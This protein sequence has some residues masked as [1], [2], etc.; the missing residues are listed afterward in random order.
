MQDRIYQ[1]SDHYKVD[2]TLV[3][4]IISCEST[5]SSTRVGVNIDKKTGK[6]WSYDIGFWQINNYF[7]EK[8]AK[9]A[10]FDIY[11][12]QQNLEYG[13]I[14]LK[15]DGAKRHWSASSSCWSA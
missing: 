5:A 15:K 6:A 4:R 8:E 11:D 3:E 10:G 13:F 9:D 1:L 2:P 12:P 14:M 7:H